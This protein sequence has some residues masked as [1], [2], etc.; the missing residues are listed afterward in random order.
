MSITV[1]DTVEVMYRVIVTKITIDGESVLYGLEGDDG[2]RKMV[3]PA[4]SCDRERIV[5]L[6]EDMN[7][8][9]FDLQKLNDL[10]CN[11]IS[12]E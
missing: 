7:K 6:V 9:Q 10:I 1:F 2:M 3:I 4:L 11:S 5:S 12:T 8:A